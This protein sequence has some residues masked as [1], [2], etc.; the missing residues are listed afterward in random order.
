MAL[1]LDIT[2]G[3]HGT[4]NSW[5]KCAR[6]TDRLKRPYPVE[7]ME[8]ESVAEPAA[9]VHR[10]YAV[11]I[12]VECHGE[13]QRVRMEV[14]VYWTAGMRQQALAYVYAFVRKGLVYTAE[15]R[16]GRLGHDPGI[17]RSEVR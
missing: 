11:V 6:C 3:F 8:L 12:V 2:T 1:D 16:R 13:K 17:L 15:V 5:I 4:Y 14:P 10:K 9:S 7:T